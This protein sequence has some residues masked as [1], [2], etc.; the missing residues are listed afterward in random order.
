MITEVEAYRGKEDKARHAHKG[1][2]A[3]T[4][5]LFRE[6]GLLYVYLI[7]GMYW[8]LNIVTGDKNDASAVLIRGLQNISGP[9]R[10]GKVLHLDESYY[11]G[12]I[13]TSNRIWIEDSNQHPE[14][15]AHPRIGIHYADEPWMS[16]PWRF[17]AKF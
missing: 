6:G 15:T 4:D 12:N 7:Y 9:G 14:Y 3:Q 17:V 13:I 16:K 1:K 5:V 2:S 8:M 11:G 10:V